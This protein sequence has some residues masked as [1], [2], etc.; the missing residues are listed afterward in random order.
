M[1]TVAPMGKTKEAIFFETPEVSVT[2]FM[3]SG[4][5]T[6]VEQVENPVIKAGGIP[7]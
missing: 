7:L 5:V 4:R 2:A 6:T 1:F 3:V